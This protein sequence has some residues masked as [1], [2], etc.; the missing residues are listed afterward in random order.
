MV[1][2][3]SSGYIPIL[4]LLAIYLSIYHEKYL[5]IKVSVVLSIYTLCYVSI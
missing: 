3:L 4:L 5:S 2:P 1:S